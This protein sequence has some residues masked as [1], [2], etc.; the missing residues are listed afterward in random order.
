MGPRARPLVLCS[1]CAFGFA[2]VSSSPVDPPGALEL[3]FP[4]ASSLADDGGP[5]ASSPAR[6][7]LNRSAN[8]LEPA[9]FNPTDCLRTDG[10]AVKV[11]G[12]ATGTTGF[13]R[14]LCC[15]AKAS[16]TWCAL[17]AEGVVLLL[18]ALARFMRFATASGG[19][20]ASPSCAA[21]ESFLV[22][23]ALAS[24][25]LAFIASF[26]LIKLSLSSSFLSRTGTPPVILRPAFPLRILSLSKS[27]AT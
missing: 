22:S 21:G 6:A 25:A 20:W 4:L 1:S 3:D 27:G 7:G 16:G 15:R 19:A 17:S 12:F 24:A 13:P 8:L 5:R 10:C 18:S 9:G 14:I 11:S 2:D 23:A 26:C